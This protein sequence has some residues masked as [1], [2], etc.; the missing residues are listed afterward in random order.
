MASTAGRD[1]G[2][3]QKGAAGGGAHAAGGATQQQPPPRVQ[4]YYNPR[5]AEFVLGAEHPMQPRR[6]ALVHKLTQHC[7]LL[8]DPHLQL[9]S[10][11]EPASLEL[12][13]RFHTPEYLSVL[14]EMASLD[15][16]SIQPAQ[17]DAL[18]D[19]LEDYGLSLPSTTAPQAAAAQQQPTSAEATGTDGDTAMAAADG[20]P[21]AEAGPAATGGGDGGAGGGGGPRSGGKGGKEEGGAPGAPNG[22]HGEASGAGTSSVP[23][24]AAPAAGAGT[25]AP[26]DTAAKEAKDSDKKHAKESRKDKKR[27]ENHNAASPTS[28]SS[29]DSSDEED[30]GEEDDIDSDGEGGDCPLFPGLLTYAQI[31]AAGSVEVRECV[32]PRGA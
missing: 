5:L 9:V 28:A 23:Q 10:D 27:D 7:G 18:R 12:L 2:V 26:S 3:G 32:C 4:L 15:P 31:Q 20:A 29:S 13:R 11:Y 8:D 25:A 24:A 1:G 19:K 21:G 17:R 22:S 14:Q 16:Y 6:L 30:D